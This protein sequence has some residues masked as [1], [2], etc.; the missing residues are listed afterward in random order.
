MC[1]WVRVKVY[2]VGNCL[3]DRMEQCFILPPYEGN[4]LPGFTIVPI[5][6]LTNLLA[7]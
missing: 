4:L 1:K 3:K 5:V 6:P 2:L 7:V